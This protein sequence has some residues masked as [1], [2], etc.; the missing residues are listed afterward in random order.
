VAVPMQLFLKY[1]DMGHELLNVPFFIEGIE[2][3]NRTSS[4]KHLKVSE[5]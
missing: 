3:E 1:T 5:E 2:M 4:A